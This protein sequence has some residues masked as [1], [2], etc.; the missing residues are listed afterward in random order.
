MLL[1]LQLRS[2]CFILRKV[3]DQGQAKYG[4]Q[5][6]S[7]LLG[8]FS[9]GLRAGAYRFTVSSLPMG[10][11]C[12]ALM[13]LKPIRSWVG[14]QQVLPPLAYRMALTLAPQV[15]KRQWAG[16]VVVEGR[17][18][19]KATGRLREVGPASEQEG[20]EVAG[21]GLGWEWWWWAGVQGQCQG[22]QGK[23][24]GVWGPPGSITWCLQALPGFSA[25]AMHLWGKPH[26]MESAA[27]PHSV[28]A[29]WGTP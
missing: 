17:E 29:W 27:W 15:G 10:C 21:E 3:V 14:M 6:A 1:S 23:V 24:A 28:R 22:T 7:G 26:V 11:P 25:R 16:E 2:N 18:D 19:G 4:L 20:K 5:A 8:N 9:S 12:C 13:G